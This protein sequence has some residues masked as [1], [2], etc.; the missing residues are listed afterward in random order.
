MSRS[1]QHSRD[2]TEPRASSSASVS[3][4]AGPAYDPS[5]FSA[6]SSRGWGSQLSIETCSSSDSD[7]SRKPF[8][9]TL[10]RPDG[11]VEVVV[12]D[13]AVSRSRLSTVF[14]SLGVTPHDVKR[15]TFSGFHEMEPSYLND[16]RAAFPSLEVIEL[17]ACNGYGDDQL[18]RQ[19]AIWDEKGGAPVPNVWIFSDGSETSAG[20]TDFLTKA[21]VYSFG[22]ARSYDYSEVIS[23]IRSMKSR[24]PAYTT[25]QQGAVRSEDDFTVSFLELEKN[26][27]ELVVT[28][29]SP[30]LFDKV[31]AHAQGV[32]L[33]NVRR[34]CIR[35]NRVID[36]RDVAKI[37]L[38]L[39]RLE[40]VEFDGCPGS[41]L[42]LS[43]NII[44]DMAA[45]EPY[46]MSVP[47]V[48]LFSNSAGPEA[49]TPEETQVIYEST[50][51]SRLFLLWVKKHTHSRDHE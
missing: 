19:V 42:A 34:L 1:N 2:E 27:V 40:R 6:S 29:S 48:W 22:K 10:K 46:R 20:R 8:T 3:R 39:Y 13:T 47:R 45:I 11:S 31:Q 30:F 41:M 18:A 38:L 12:Y 5:S 32:G 36:T 44:R 23:G 14:R 24:P 37:V 16:A 51:M 26:Y 35:G 43:E 28:G 9:K 21:G 17:H 50:A 7:S 49:P 4:S 33:Q 25:R 15:I